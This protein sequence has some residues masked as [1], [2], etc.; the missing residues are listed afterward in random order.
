MT[1]LR[2]GNPPRRRRSRYPLRLAV[3]GVLGV[4]VSVEAVLTVAPLIDLY[5]LP[6][7]PSAWLANL[8]LIVALASSLF[9]ALAMPKRVPRRVRVH[10]RARRWVHVPGP[11]SRD[12]LTALPP[13]GG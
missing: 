2:I 6:T 8:L 4:G 5:L 3:A 1:T 11:P 9:M 7:H 10:A 12:R 13:V